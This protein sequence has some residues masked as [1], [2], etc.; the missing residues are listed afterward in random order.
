M[1]ASMLAAD[2][3]ACDGLLLLAYPLHPPGRP[4]QLRDAHFCTFGVVGT[5]HARAPGPLRP[6]SPPRTDVRFRPLISA[7]SRSST[8]PSVGNGK[9]SRR[10]S[11]ISRPRAC[12]ASTAVSISTISGGD[13]R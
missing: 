1:A 4:E 11:T 9:S 10:I 3:F 5:T 2:G 7:R 13:R 8:G 12:T 6:V